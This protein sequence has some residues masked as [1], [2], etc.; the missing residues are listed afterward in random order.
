MPITAD[1]RRQTDRQTDGRR[2]IANMNMS[3]RSL[4]IVFCFY[5]RTHTHPDYKRK[6]T[7]ARRSSTKVAN[8]TQEKSWVFVCKEIVYFS[9]LVTVHSTTRR[10][11]D[12]ANGWAWVVTTCQP[13][14][15]K[16]TTCVN[17]NTLWSEL[18]QRVNN[19]LTTCPRHTLL[20]TVVHT[21]TRCEL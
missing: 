16:R 9:H 10:K 20:F 8:G 2:H 4:K 15:T 18:S 14:L 21:C 12:A 5:F 1:D 7:H 11:T 3:S 6:N 17:M 13:L 19:V